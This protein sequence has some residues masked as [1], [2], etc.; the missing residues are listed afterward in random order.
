MLVSQAKAKEKQN[1]V[2][3]SNKSRELVQALP[4]EELFFTIK[5]IGETDAIQ[6]IELSSPAQM[7]YFFDVEFWSKHR[8][9]V[10]AAIKWLRLI[11]KC[12]R[13]KLIEVLH[14][15]D[16]DLLRLLL[17]KYLRVYKFES[18]ET[19]EVNKEFFTL[20]GVYHLDLKYKKLGRIEIQN[21]IGII[22]DVD[23]DLYVRLMESLY[24]EID[25]EVEEQAFHFRCARMADRGFPDISEAQAIYQFVE[26]D[27]YKFMIKDKRNFRAMG[28]R[29]G[30]MATSH[31]LP[32]GEEKS[33]FA[34][35]ISANMGREYFDTL[36]GEVVSI[37]N[38][39]LIV[40]AVNLSDVKSVSEILEK[41]SGY[42]N[43]GLE[44]LSKGDPERAVHMVRRFY[45]EDIFRVG[46]SLLLKLK[47][48]AAS[49]K[50][51]ERFFP[52]DD[53]WC[54]LSAPYEDLIQG[55][56]QAH[57]VL[58]EGVL[59][60]GSGK[61]RYF[62]NMS[63]VNSIDELLQKMLFWGELHFSVYG[64]IVE[65]IRKLNLSGCYPC[66]RS[67]ID[68]R[69]LSLTAFANQVLDG[70]FRFSPVE[71]NRLSLFLSSIFQKGRRTPLRL[72][73]KVRQDCYRW[74]RSLLKDK[75]GKKIVYA[76][77]FW[78]A[79]FDFLEEEFGHLDLEKP[80]DPRFANGLLIVLAM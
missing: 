67:D 42:I 40:D 20:D 78:D 44:Y 59:N 13:D 31:Y 64:F 74:L 3:S 58:Y 37:S 23:T 9:T 36:M 77:E 66:K 52:G 57:P 35:S 11:Q 32:S 7:E 50:T 27:S 33:L 71:S 61:Y 15:M 19:V 10:R 51:D 34:R 80:I 28:D 21:L 47:R 18:E 48:K 12:G 43:I 53:G 14:H 55:L 8:F 5:E 63:E 25:S 2:L 22:R 54:L 70:Q 69:I 26:P 30:S 1:L 56:T 68:F 46:F 24:W 17:G 75:N 4:E 16:F 38:K 60:P 72:K 79:C 45:L 73:R 65:D 76:Q 29:W 39:A 49:I 6:L 62:R 41:T